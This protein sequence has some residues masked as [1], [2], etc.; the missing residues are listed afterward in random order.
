[1]DEFGEPAGLR[2][3]K[4]SFAVPQFCMYSWL[5][6]HQ[7]PHLAYSCLLQSITG[8]YRY[9]RKS[10]WQQLP[11]ARGKPRFSGSL[12]SVSVD[13]FIRQTPCRTAMTVM[14][15]S[16]IRGLSTTFRTSVCTSM[17]CRPACSLE[18]DVQPSCAR[19]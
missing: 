7:W 15:P 1:M 16:S 17:I 3:A 6:Q 13:S 10:Y 18:S 19:A 14:T 5:T 9:L 4:H 2:D 12:S 11:M 8:M